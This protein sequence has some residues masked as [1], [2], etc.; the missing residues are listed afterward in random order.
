MDLEKRLQSN[1]VA[2]LTPWYI[3]DTIRNM[4]ATLFYIS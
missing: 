4:R 2:K 1:M 3:R